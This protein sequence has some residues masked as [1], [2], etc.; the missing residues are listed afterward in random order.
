MNTCT[1]ESDAK[2]LLKRYS[3]TTTVEQL[4][5][6]KK[7]TGYTWVYIADLLGVSERTLYYYASAKH[8]IPLS[9]SKLLA[10]LRR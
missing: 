7:Q 1:L 9:I 8:N 10:Q 6:W 4:K 3:A 2:L 5:T